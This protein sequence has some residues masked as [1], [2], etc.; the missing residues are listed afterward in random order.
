MPHRQV[1]AADPLPSVLIVEDEAA[2][3][4][5]YVKFLSDRYRVV[6]TSCGGGALN[7]VSGDAVDLIVLDYKLPDISG[8]EVLKEI[9]RSKP[10]IPVIVV[11]GY[12]DED[13]AVTF[14]RCGARDY[15]KKPFSYQELVSK[16]DF[17]LSLKQSAQGVKQEFLYEEQQS[18]E[19]KALSDLHSH[20][21]IQKALK[22]L[23]YNY[24]AKISLDMVAKKA[25]MSKHHFSRVF[26][27]VIGKGY[28]EYLNE[29][30]IKK[31]K[32]LLQ[33]GNLSVTEVAFSV[34]YADLTHF[35]RMFKS[36][37]NITPSQYKSPARK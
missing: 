35:E 28:Q 13:V 1:Q 3:S 14:F 23:D 15:I 36:I 11:T 22:F 25:C 27:Q 10:L 16:I 31:A 30:R 4:Q 8:I 18:P 33:R 9:K 12:G 21:K 20:F 6:T 29:L 24:I 5:C 19:G 2:I 17:Y 37:M 7:H 26:K 32:E 34:G